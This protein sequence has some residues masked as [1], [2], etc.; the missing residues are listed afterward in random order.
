MNGLPGMEF[1]G[2]GNSFVGKD[3]IADYLEDY[4]GIMELPVRS[5]VRVERLD[6]DG[7]WFTVT[8]SEGDFAAR[9][10]IIAMAD[11]QKPKIPDFAGSLDE[12]I[13]QLHS[14]TRIRLSCEMGRRW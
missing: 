10:V 14:N 7:D 1:P 9:N 2:P 8:T 11:Y 4:A 12:N 13:V 5:G 3:Q 6:R